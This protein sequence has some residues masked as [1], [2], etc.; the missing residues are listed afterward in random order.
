M[1]KIIYCLL[2]LVSACSTPGTRTPQSANDLIGDLAKFKAEVSEKQIQ[3]QNCHER[4]EEQLQ[5]LREER[6]QQPAV[7]DT[8]TKAEAVLLG[9]WQLRLALQKNLGQMLSCRTELRSLFYRL[10]A[11]QDLAGDRLYN[12]KPISPVGLDFQKQPVPLLENAPYHGYLDRHGKVS[13]LPL[14][15]ESGDLLLTRGVSFFSAML[16]AITTIPNQVDHFVFIN[17]DPKGTLQSMESYAQDGGVS[18]FA[19]DF[20]LK[21]EN[22]RILVLRAKDHKMANLASEKMMATILQGEKT[23]KRIGYDYHMDLSQS[24]RMT[25]A[26]VSYWSFKNASEGRYAIPEEIST[27]DTRLEPITKAAEIASAQV[28]TAQDMEVDSRFDIIAEFTDYRL[29]RDGRYRDAVLQS[30]LKW[31]KEDKYL[32]RADFN[33]K[34]IDYVIYPT[35]KY[36]IGKVIRRAA[37]I[38]DFPPDTPKGFLKLLKQID[39]LG[40]TLYQRV[41]SED[42]RFVEKTGWSLTTDQMLKILEDYRLEDMENYLSTGHSEF[43]NHFRPKKLKRK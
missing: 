17:K 7:A 26:A 42:Q 32:L 1:K 8:P 30:I 13:L 37:D 16:S 9:T 5:V 38:P 2:I 18:R 29:L 35:R 12:E 22:A 6:L 21:N 24:D 23:G 39:S 40:K 34:A 43:H 33:T 41:L 11:I 14:D 20:A 36:L 10:R 15:I 28:L 4:L 25:C 3:N 19:M 31:I 27:L